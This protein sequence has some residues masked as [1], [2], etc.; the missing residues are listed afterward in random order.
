VPARKQATAAAGDRPAPRLRRAYYDCRFGQLHVHNA[1]PGG[2]GFDELTAAI[3]LPDTGET[4]RVFQPLLQTLGFDRSVYS[5]DLPGSGE[6]DPAPGVLPAD[7]AFQAVEDFTGTMR[8]RQFDLVAHGEACMV[9]RRLARQLGGAV[10]RLVLLGE[11]TPGIPLE[12]KVLS[13]PRS[14]AD[15]AGFAARV[16]DFLAAGM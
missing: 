12:Q 8:I 11:V 1:I 5:L 9:A 4:G 15:A 13:L 10:R 6:S 16:A 2:G 7:A 3:C 14:D